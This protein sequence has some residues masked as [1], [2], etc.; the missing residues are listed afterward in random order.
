MERA[1]SGTL[2][3]VTKLEAKDNSNPRVNRVESLF[4]N[5]DYRLFA[6]KSKT[7]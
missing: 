2:A 5:P 1:K 6:L 7:R 3:Q 4:D